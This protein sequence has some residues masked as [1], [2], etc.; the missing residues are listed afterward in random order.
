MYTLT[1]EPFPNFKGTPIL[2]MGNIRFANKPIDN[3]YY[4]FKP[5]GGLTS[6]LK[7]DTIQ[8]RKGG[9]YIIHHRINNLPNCPSDYFDTLVVPPL[10][11][12]DLALGPD[13]FVCAGTT[14]R[15]GSRAANGVPRFTYKWFYS[16]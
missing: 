10:L 7:H 6:R 5:K 2:P 9:K 3:S 4:Y 15:L 11:E 12:V 14:L 13:S 1:S 8:F 16:Y